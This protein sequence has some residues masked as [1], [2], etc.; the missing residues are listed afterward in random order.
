M[1]KLVLLMNY[2][3]FMLMNIKFSVSLI[4]SVTTEIDRAIVN[5][6]QKNVYSNSLEIHLIIFI[7]L[8][9]V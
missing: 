2:L 1:T 8:I 6:Y 5:E 3:F 4:T 9:I 7:L